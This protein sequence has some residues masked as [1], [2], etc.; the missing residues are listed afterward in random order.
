MDK[1]VVGDLRFHTKIG[2][3][4]WERSVAQPV[5]VNLEIGL[6][7]S[8]ACASDDLRDALDYALVIERVEAMLRAHPH[9]LL[10]RLAEAIAQVVLVDCGAP[11]VKVAVAKIAPL[12]G[13]KFIAVSIE[14]ER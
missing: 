5:L 12:P 1:I 6:A 7:S 3:Y 9:R 2:V 4:E 8:E 10:E 14:R 11:W 13:V